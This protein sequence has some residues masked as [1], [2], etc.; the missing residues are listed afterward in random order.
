MVNSGSDGLY[1]Y[2]DSSQ[3]L[4]IY[5]DQPSLGPL[6]VQNILWSLYQMIGILYKQFL[7]CEQWRF[8]N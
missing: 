6:D 2:A 3:N 1:L 8:G 7:I 4:T 5:I